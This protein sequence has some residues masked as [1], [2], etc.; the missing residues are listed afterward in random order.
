MQ[1]MEPPSHNTAKCSYSKD[2]IV[3]FQ[4][5]VVIKSL[6]QDLKFWSVF[7]AITWVW[8]TLFAF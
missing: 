3:I 6:L 2:T 5:N 7:V 1:G 8:D 4:K